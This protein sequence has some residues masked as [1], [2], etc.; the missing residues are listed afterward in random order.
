MHMIESN[1]NWKGWKIISH[2]QKQNVWLGHLLNIHSRDRNLHKVNG[3][4]IVLKLAP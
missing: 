3:A 2:G 1:E 4:H